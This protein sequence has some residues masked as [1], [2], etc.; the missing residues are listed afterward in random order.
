MGD[1]ARIAG[2]FDETS[3]SSENFYALLERESKKAAFHGSCVSSA[4]VARNNY[5]SSKIITGYKM[6]R[7]SR[8]IY[9]QNVSV[10]GKN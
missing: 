9:R 2:V 5:K 1:G 3:L 6:P 8:G 10:S 7:W 4:V